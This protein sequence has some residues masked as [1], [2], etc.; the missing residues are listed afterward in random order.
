[1]KMMKRLVIVFFGL[2]A[3]LVLSSLGTL[4]KTF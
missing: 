1:M 3:L 4:L 2:S